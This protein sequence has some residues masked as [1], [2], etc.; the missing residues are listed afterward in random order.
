MAKQGEIRVW[1]GSAWIDGNQVR[2]IVAATSERKAADL[3]PGLSYSYL[4]SHWAVTGNHIEIQTALD[5]PGVVFKS[6]DIR[7][8]H[9]YEEVKT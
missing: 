2:C 7:R 6:V 5:R 1:G 9:L 8:R 4:R 3:V